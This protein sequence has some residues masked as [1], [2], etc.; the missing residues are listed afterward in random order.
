MDADD[1]YHSQL[2]EI[3]EETW[4]RHDPV[5]LHWQYIDVEKSSD[6]YV[7]DNSD[8]KYDCDDIKIVSGKD[9][10]KYNF[11]TGKRILDIHA[12]GWR[13]NPRISVGIA[14]MSKQMVKNYR[15]PNF[16]GGED[17]FIHKEICWDHTDKVMWL[18]CPLTQYN[19]KNS[20]HDDRDKN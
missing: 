12:Q 14:A 4:R 19:Y 11:P 15:W 7:Q 8:T 17:A 20:V 9:I 6:V 16:I 5:E 18:L 10:W 2:V 1:R 13:Y 3:V